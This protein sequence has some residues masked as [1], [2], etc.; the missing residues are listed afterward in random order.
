VTADKLDIEYA[1]DVCA[2]YA[3]KVSVAQAS[4]TLSWKVD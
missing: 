4:I 3:I 1:I 2:G